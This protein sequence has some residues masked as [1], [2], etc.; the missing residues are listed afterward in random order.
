VRFS[1]LIISWVFV[2]LGVFVTSASSDAK[3]LRVLAFGD[4]L[5]AGYRLPAKQAWPARLEEFLKAGGLDV[6]VTNGGVSGDTSGGA[7][8]R[9]EW[10]LKFGPYDLAIV[11][12][13]ANDGLR[14][15]PVK[16]MEANLRKIVEKFHAA[17]VKVLLLGMKM[18][19]NLDAEYRA[20]FEA[21]YPKLAKELKLE[22]YPFVL[23]G[24]ALNDMLNLSDRIHPNPQGHEIIARALEK[25]VGPLLK[26]K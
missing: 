23:E 9:V 25:R 3:P 16:D 1:A 24:I 13:G 20:Q 12:L 26:Q 6:A 11:G 14:Q 8:R 15:L 17:K 2:A 4:S 22:L 10:N 21:V 19:S 5:T 7:L 18:P